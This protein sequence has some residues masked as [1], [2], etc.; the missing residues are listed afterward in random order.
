[1]PCL[2]FV[3]SRLFL[4]KPEV[5]V[6]AAGLLT[7]LV[8]G[9]FP[10]KFWTVAWWP[11]MLKRLTA[12]GTVPDFHRIPYYPFSREWRQRHRR[13]DKCKTDLQIRTT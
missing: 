13:R 10:P 7:R 6:A 9:A 11:K 5:Y 2:Q 3:S 8:F 1:M 12:A 4:R